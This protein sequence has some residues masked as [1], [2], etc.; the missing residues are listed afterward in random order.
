MKHTF[1][2][3]LLISSTCMW[4]QNC[5]SSI[6]KYHNSFDTTTLD[7]IIEVELLELVD[8]QMYDSIISC[9]EQTQKKYIPF[10]EDPEGVYFGI[11]FE[12]QNYYKGIDYYHYYD[13]VIAP[14]DNATLKD[15]NAAIQWSNHLS[16]P[17]YSG[18][19]KIEGAFYMKGYLFVAVTR[20]AFSNE[21]IE[22]YYKHTDKKIKLM[23]YKDE[24]LKNADMIRPYSFRSVRY[25]VETEKRYDFL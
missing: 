10:L 16:A 23:I 14:H 15:L 20:K 6:E 9:I 24:W 21:D 25:T 17:D 4:S 5:Y 13:V 7:T 19:K 11:F 18:R 1:F 22:K 8:S 2:L 12:R 3:L